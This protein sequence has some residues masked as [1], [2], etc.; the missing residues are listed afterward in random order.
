MGDARDQGP[1]RLQ[2]RPTTLSAQRQVRRP[3][4]CCTTVLPPSPLPASRRSPPAS[5]GARSAV[6]AAELSRSRLAGALTPAYPGPHPLGGGACGE[7]WAS[8]GPPQHSLGSLS[9]VFPHP[10]PTPTPPGG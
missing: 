2:D 4:H 10:T 6:P 8:H 9:T 3:L 5:H 7:A 1:P